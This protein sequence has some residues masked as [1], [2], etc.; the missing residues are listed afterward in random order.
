MTYLRRLQLQRA[1]IAAAA[2]A[3]AAK[4]PGPAASSGAVLPDAP[5]RDGG[6]LPAPKVDR[7]VSLA[8]LRRTIG[9]LFG[10]GQAVGLAPSFVARHARALET[11]SGA[12]TKLQGA[13]ERRSAALEALEPGL[14]APTTQVFGRLAHAASEALSAATPEAAREQLHTLI[15]GVT[16][17]LE[18]GLRL[19]P[20]HLTALEDTAR[21]LATLRAEDLGAVSLRALSAI[22]ELPTSSASAFSVLASRLDVILGAAA[23]GGRKELLEAAIEVAATHAAGDAAALDR[24]GLTPGQRKILQALGKD[25][26]RQVRDVARGEK[27]AAAEVARATKALGAIDGKLA[28]SAPLFARASR[29][30]PPPRLAAWLEAARLHRDRPP[31]ETYAALGALLEVLGRSAEV[32]EAGLR[33]LERAAASLAK[34][35]GVGQEVLT[36]V[37]TG[38]ARREPAESLPGLLEVTAR[39]LTKAAEER[40]SAELVSRLADGLTGRTKA[41]A[42]EDGPLA[43]TAEALRQVRA[44]RIDPAIVAASLPRFAE[45]ARKA[46]AGSTRDALEARFPADAAALARAKLD[47]AGLAAAHASIPEDSLLRLTALGLEREQ[48]PDAWL[49]SLGALFDR[50][51]G[52]KEYVRALRSLFVLCAEGGADVV[53]LAGALG[54]AEL[55]PQQLARTANAILDAENRRPTKA[56]VDQAIA[57]LGRGED[58]ALAIETQLRRAMMKELDF[59]RLIKGDVQVTEEGFKA[60]S[61]PLADFFAQAVNDG[62]VERGLLQKVL[63]A[64]LEDRIQSF[65]FETKATARQL[66]CLSPEQRRRWEA[67]E[68]MTH[69][70]LDKHARAE[71]DGR[72][73][74]SAALGQE[75]LRR[76]SAAWGDLAELQ[77]EHG[78]RVALLRDVPKNKVAERQRL[79][80]EVT[81]LPS[82]IRAMQWA[83]ELAAL[84]PETTTPLRFAALSDELPRLGLILGPG[85]RSAVE[86]LLWTI[87][88]DD[89]QYSEVVTTDGP[90]L[91]TMVHLAG[92]NC[93]GGDNASM[94][95]YCL[96]PNKKMIVT[97]NQAGEE[98]RS[99]VR[100]VE[101]KDRGH[102][103][104]P[105]LVLERTYPDSASEDEK[106]RLV[107]HVLRRATDL[108]IPAAY[109]LE[110]YWDVGQ[111]SRFRGHGD[112]HDT[113]KVIED[114]NRRYGTTAEKRTMQVTSRAG[115]MGHEYIDSAPLAGAADAGNVQQRLYGGGKDVTYEN[116]FMVLEPKNEGIAR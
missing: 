67:Q 72:I 50:T 49:A 54:K 97:K 43:A 9:D 86:E 29:E 111:T 87:R 79:I 66:A 35:P 112:V 104:E 45:A 96:D 23:E 28:P 44:A 36:A 103:G 31:L 13:I 115:N 10:V 33:R 85:M 81:G 71:L 77:R 20:Q 38:P 46:E 74:A 101:R 37:L 24:P 88:I 6:T 12:L 90:D 92:T 27:A 108:G 18:G 25:V 51:R 75:L 100:L 61:G 78:E 64:A 30:L 48:A 4:G 52:N 107:E 98:R 105:M 65:R 58:V 82:R 102:V 19:A 99:V 59:E 80:G 39:T 41:F 68:T 116:H 2:P 47:P 62:D 69:V 15:T 93:L 8:H 113:K 32:P 16:A 109:P 91:A 53:R 89:L 21:A 106:R 42:K 7:G 5:L 40:P 17:A 110:Y 57:M 73:H 114:L 95:A 94:L 55:R 83:A 26:E 76:M 3:G 60:V 22:A 56:K 84:T 1:A 14:G 11:E 63:V 34:V 70:R